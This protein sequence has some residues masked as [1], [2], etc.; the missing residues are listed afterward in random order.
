[1]TS[2]R[3]LAILLIA[4]G[5]VFAGSLAVGAASTHQRHSGIGRHVR[6]RGGL[7]S[8]GHC[9][10]FGLYGD[11]TTPPLVGRLSDSSDNLT[12]VGTTNGLYVVAPGGKLH[13]FLYSPFGIKHIALID[14]I[15]DDG[16][17][18]VVVALN[19]TQVPALRCYDGATWERLWQ[20]APMARIWENGWV[21]RQLLISN[22]DVI[23]CRGSQNVVFTSGRCLFSVDAK[24]GTKQW[25]FKGPS[26][27]RRMVT[28]ADLNGDSADEVFVGSDDGRLYL[29]SGKSGQV[30]W[31]TKLPKPKSTDYDDIARMLSDIAVLDEESGTRW[32]SPR[33]TVGR[34]C[35]AWKRRDVSGKRPFLMKP[36]RRA[37]HHRWTSSCRRLPT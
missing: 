13:H 25:Q 8:L 33:Q 32:W 37:T 9:T 29:L 11:I 17:R 27:L 18:E 36:R 30:R 22:L 28:L 15:T 23:T 16:I 4:A 5:I 34:G 12:F 10:P 3:L 35:T 7:R 6:R 24:D 20:F 1:M 2:R 26:S 21:N 19:D 14:D 31:R